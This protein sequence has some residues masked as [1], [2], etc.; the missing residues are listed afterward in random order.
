MTRG[1]SENQKQ[2]LKV[3]FTA[4]LAGLALV[5]GYIEIRWPIAPWL[6]LDFSEVI[7]LLS[8]IMIGF[9]HT[10]GV[11][12]IR[13]VIRWLITA[14]STNIPFPFFGETVAIIA[15]IVV[16]LVY[17]L[18]NFIFRD[19]DYE[20]A[21]SKERRLPYPKL[22]N[23]TAIRVFKDVGK[24]VFVTI[25]LA[26][27]MVAINFFIVTPSF[28]SQGQHIFFTSFVNSG[29]YAGMIG[30]TG[31]RNYTIF[32]TTLYGPF[33][34]LKFASCLIIFT[35]IKKQLVKVIDLRP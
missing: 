8:L 28:A 17:M 33:N 7:I 4:I 29:D 26:A 24:I 6:K 21:K 27:F 13:S 10:L 3:V 16:V 25:I 32:V 15:S 35:I 34:L 23:E 12:V 22:R 19:N 18:A 31:L 14:D 9:S 1:V 30:G 5:V 11:I 2:L 20:L